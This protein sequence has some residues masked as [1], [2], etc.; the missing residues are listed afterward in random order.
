MQFHT[1]ER[2]GEKRGDRKEGRDRKRGEI[3]RRKERGGKKERKGRR[4][5]LMIKSLYILQKVNISLRLV[6]YK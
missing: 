2:G 6:T 3:E 5:E 1:N 4:N